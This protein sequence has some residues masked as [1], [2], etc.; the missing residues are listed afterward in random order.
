MPAAVGIKGVLEAVAVALGKELEDV[1]TCFVP[2]GA[3]QVERF[4]HSF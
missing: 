3:I 1:T 2:Y 4:I